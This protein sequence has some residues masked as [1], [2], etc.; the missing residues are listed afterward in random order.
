M[1]RENYIDLNPGVMLG[2]PVITGTRI[3]V[4]LIQRKLRSG[5]TIDDLLKSYPHL[6]K[7]QV[8]AASEYAA[9]P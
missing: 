1:D 5:Y 2:K 7:E 4:E 8:L 6:S 3:T 9:K